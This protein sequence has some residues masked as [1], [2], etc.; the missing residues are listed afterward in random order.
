MELTQIIGYIVPGQDPMPIYLCGAAPDYP[1]PSDYIM[2]YYQEYGYYG[3]GDSLNPQVFEAAGQTNQSN[4][5]TQ[6]NQYIAD[7]QTTGN[8]TLAIK[9]YDQAEVLGVNLTIYVYT[10]QQNGFW[11][12]SSVLH[13]VQYEQNPMYAGGQETVYI[14]LSK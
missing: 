12:Y 7:A 10:D 3:Y 14:Y 8:A 4:L 13:G 5:I 1:F 9:Y 2:D 11:F 6:M